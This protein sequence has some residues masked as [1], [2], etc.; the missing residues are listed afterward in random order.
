MSRFYPVF[1]KFIL[2][3]YVLNIFCNPIRNNRMLSQEMYT[4]VTLFYIEFKN[5]SGTFGTPCIISGPK[6]TFKNTL[7]L[8]ENYKC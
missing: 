6:H 2:K 1:R 5:M 3:I 4:K 7:L 8:D